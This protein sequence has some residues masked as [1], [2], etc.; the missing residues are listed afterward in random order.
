MRKYNVSEQTGYSV[1]IPDGTWEKAR[2]DLAKEGERN[3]D[4]RAIM[5]YIWC[6]RASYD[7][8]IVETYYDNQIEEDC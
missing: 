7:L 5:D 6:Y 8:D 3:P 2:S 4:D 1:E